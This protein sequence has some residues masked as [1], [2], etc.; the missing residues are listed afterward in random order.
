MLADIKN[1]LL[2]LLNIIE[3]VEKILH[4]LNDCSKAEDFYFLNDQ[5]NFNA[6]LNLFSHI[7]DNVAKISNELK[8]KHNEIDWQA[9]KG[10]RNRIAHDYVNV[11]HFI[12]FDII[13]KDLQPLGNK[14]MAIISNELKNGTFDQKELEAA[15]DSYYYRHVHFDKLC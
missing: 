9:V 14:V 15:R 7:G 13:K 2:Y 1:D 5:L 6:S 4:Y 3:S 11:D 12:V 8:A 10:F